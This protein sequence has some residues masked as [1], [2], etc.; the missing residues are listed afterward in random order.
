MELYIYIY[1]Y[2]WINISMNNYELFHNWKDSPS[3]SQSLGT[4][5]TS[6]RVFAWEEWEKLKDLHDDAL[7]K[8]IVS[9][10]LEPLRDSPGG[11]DGIF[12]CG[13]PWVLMM[14]SMKLNF[15]I[16]LEK[17][18]KLDFWINLGSLWIQVAS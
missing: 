16:N 7:A 9:S 4:S 17:K 12:P 10:S 6:R 5:W 14:K 1:I 18:M 13:F 8:M 11:G 15:W 2:K 3:M